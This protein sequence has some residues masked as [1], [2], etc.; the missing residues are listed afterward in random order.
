MFTL[1]IGNNTAINGKIYQQFK[2]THILNSGEKAI[3]EKYEI[4]SNDSAN[5]V[6]V[7]NVEKLCP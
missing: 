2:C 4:F 1:F 3:E 7:I 6:T 5:T